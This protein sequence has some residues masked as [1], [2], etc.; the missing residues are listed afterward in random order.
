MSQIISKKHNGREIAIGEISVKQSNIKNEL[1]TVFKVYHQGPHSEEDLFMFRYNKHMKDWVLDLEMS[2]V[3][4]SYKTNYRLIKEVYSDFKP[5]EP[6][7]IQQFTDLLY[8]AHFE[9]FVESNKKAFKCRF[10]FKVFLKRMF[11]LKNK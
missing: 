3:S 8:D 5:D 10:T 1:V 11:G 4:L 9:I 2:L 7:N 6:L